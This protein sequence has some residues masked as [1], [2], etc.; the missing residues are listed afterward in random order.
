MESI[1][2]LNLRLDRVA[3]EN[4]DWKRVLDV[5]DRPATFFF[6]DPP[7]TDCDA[8]M[9]SAWTTADVLAF[10]QR[11]DRLRGSW[12]VTLNDSKA[13]R[14]IFADCTIKAVSRPKG[15]GGKGKPYV[16]LIITPEGAK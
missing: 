7:Y 5:Y 1:R 4:M 10:R 14:Q 16:E 15:I 3:L 8:S 12:L 13:I 11:L 6:L 9:Y 2:Q